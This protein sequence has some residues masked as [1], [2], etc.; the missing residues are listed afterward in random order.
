MDSPSASEYA[1]ANSQDAQQMAKA[2]LDKTKS[3]EEKVDHLISIG[4]ATMLGLFG[5]EQSLELLKEAQRMG[6]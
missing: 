4:V 2:A 3:N 1:W 6:F 5:R